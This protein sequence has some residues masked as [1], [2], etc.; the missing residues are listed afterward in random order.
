M[1]RNRELI[2]FDDTDNYPTYPYLPMLPTSK[3]PLA[4]VAETQPLAVVKLAKWFLETEKV[5]ERN[6]T[7]CSISKDHT[8]MACTWLANRQPGE[9]N[10]DI[11]NGGFSGIKRILFPSSGETAC[12]RTRVKIW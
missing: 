4:V 9:R 6:H 1:L 3:S 12:L 11:E 8:A 2:G 7:I 10:I 5:K